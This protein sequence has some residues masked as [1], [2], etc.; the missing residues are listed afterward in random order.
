MTHSRRTV[1]PALLA[2]ALLVLAGCTGTSAP[3]PSAAPTHTSTP[4]GAKWVWAQFDEVKPYLTELK[5]G[6]TY[7]E[8]VLCDVEKSKGVFDWAVP[9]SYVT[10]AREIGI[11]SL[12]KL[13]TGRC[14]ATPGEPKFSRG[15]GVTESAMPG[16][17]GVYTDFVT[18]AVRRYSDLGVSE[19]A[20]ENEVNSPSF[21][22]GTPSEYAV[23]ARAGAQAVHAAEP[24]ALVVDGSVSSAG[25][26]Y[27]VAKGLL[28]AGREA[29]AVATY[30]AY[31]ERRF[32]TRDG[33]AAINEVASPAEL[34]AELAR[35]GPASMVAFMDVI[36]GLFDEGVLPDAPGALLRGMAGT[37]GHLDLPAVEARP[38]SVPLELWELGIWDDDRGVGKDQRVAEVVKATVIALAAGAQKVL[39]LPLLDNPA[40]RLGQ[41]LHGLVS[42]SGDVLGSASAFAL[43]ARAAADGAAVRPVTRAGLAGATFDSAP[44]T[45]VTWARGEPVALPSVSGA[46]GTTL[47]AATTV[48]TTAPAHHDG[49]EAAGPHH[50]ERPAV[51]PTGDHPVND[52]RTNLPHADPPSPDPTRLVFVGGLHRSGTTPFARILGE[53]PDVSGLEGTGVIED[54]GQHLQSVYPPGTAYGG[55]GHFARDPRAHLTETSPLATPANAERLLAAWAPYWDLRRACLVEKSPPNIVMSRFLQALYP[56]ARFIMVIRHPVTVAPVDPQVDPL[57]L[58]RPPQ[59]RQ[60]D[61]PRRALAGRSPGAARGP[62]PPAQRPPRALRGLRAEPTGH[63]RR[64]QG[65]SRPGHPD[66]DREGAWRRERRLQQTWAS[67]R[68]PVRP[69]GVQRALITRRFGEE[70]A[71]YGYD[72]DDLMSYEPGPSTLLS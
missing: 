43:I 23:L 63:V 15:H 22:D 49:H 12:V 45:M 33:E 38:T 41:T 4:L 6:H 65:L 11:T 69:G 71:A 62:S 31:Y 18:Q 1:V 57:H 68:R 72:V 53:H 34:R 2:G 51:S 60:P 48:S 21:W 47:D 64:R 3:E 42:S 58:P 27:A 40:G 20:I 37:A 14:W 52:P 67:Y 19:F 54:E 46:T 26:G 50:D 55:S 30:Q 7:V 35:P 61:R 13:R 28:D 32:G 66:P 8:V 39:W 56:D 44:A 29:D 9:D 36:N 17:M 5:G 59:V 70:I 24:S 25:A 16:D 10:R